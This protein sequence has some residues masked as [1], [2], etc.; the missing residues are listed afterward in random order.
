MHRGPKRKT[1]G[2]A[3]LELMIAFFI[4]MVLS[5][6]AGRSYTQ[7]VARARLTEC[8]TKIHELRRLA[9]D[10]FHNVEQFANS[11]KFWQTY[12]GAGAETEFVYATD[13]DKVVKKCNTNDNNKGHG[14]DCSRMDTDNRGSAGP[15]VAA[16]TMFEITCTHDHFPIADYVYVS[17]RIPNA[18][19]VKATPTP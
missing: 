16:P 19:P 14:N 13:Y 1:R 8:I 15:G 4:V 12:K 18:I 5:L 9:W 17:S 11:T 6:V 2:F 7:Y 10:Y 3:L